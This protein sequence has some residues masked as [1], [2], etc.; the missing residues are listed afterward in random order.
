MKTD[1]KRLLVVFIP[2]VI[3]MLAL[4]LFLEFVVFDYI[5]S[6]KVFRMKGPNIISALT[7]CLFYLELDSCLFHKSKSLWLGIQG[8][9]KKVVFGFSLILLEVICVIAMFFPLL[10]AFG[11]AAF[12]FLLWIGINYLFGINLLKA[13]HYP[14]GLRSE[15]SGS[16]D[17]LG[18]V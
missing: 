14:E 6:L 2:W 9:R 13:G 3:S 16:S 15:K 1:I 4:G 17:E 12:G 10:Q 11:V 18:H 8:V 5:N 7:T